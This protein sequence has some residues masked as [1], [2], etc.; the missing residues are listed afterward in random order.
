MYNAQETAKKI[1]EMAKK[2]KIS[3]AKM[4]EINNIGKGTITK[5][6]NGA[7]VFV[8]TIYKIAQT[9]SCSIDYLT[10]NEESITEEEQKIIDDYRSVDENGKKAIKQQIEYITNDERYKKYTDVPKEA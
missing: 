10:G 1:K 5:M 3:V 6:S 4:L 8:Q 7:D 2:R 9:L